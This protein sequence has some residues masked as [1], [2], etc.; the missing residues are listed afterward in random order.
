MQKI[1][2]VIDDINY[3]GGAHFA[4]FK[5]ANF[6]NKMGNQVSIY[7]PNKLQPETKGYIDSEIVILSKKDFKGYNYIVV[8]FE[9][10]IFREEVA[11]IKN[12]IKV[13]WIHIEYEKWKN[14]VNL[15]DNMQ[16][17]IYTNF[18]KLVFVSE[19]NRKSFLNVFP[20]FENKCHVVYNF[21]D[22]S[23]VCKKADEEFDE[24]IMVKRQPEQLNIV[25]SGRLEPQKAY[26]R[27]IDIVKILNEDQYL[28]DWYI[29]GAGFEYEALKERCQKYSIDNIHFLGYRKN[30]YPFVK[31]ADLFAILSEYEGLALVIAESLT[32]GVPVVSTE[33]GGVREILS[34]KYGWIIDNNIYAIIRQLRKLYIE[35]QLISEK[36]SLLDTYIYNNHQIEETIKTLFDGER[37]EKQMSDEYNKKNEKDNLK[38]IN[39]SVIVPVYNMENYLVECLD[40]LVNQT[41]ENI[42]IVIVNDGSTDNSLSI[43]NDYVYLYPDK[44][45]AFSIENSGLGEARNYGISKAKGSY[46]GFVDSD[47]FVRNDMFEIMYRAAT[48]NNADCI[49][50]DYIAIWDTGKTEYVT[51]VPIQNPDRFDILKYSAKYGVVNACT[52]LISRSLFQFVKFPEGFYEDL[53]T[54]PIVLSYSQK[55]YYVKEGLYFYRQ[56]SGSITSIKR[57]DS[58]LFDCYTAWDRIRNLSNP[59]LKKEITFA[60]YWSMNFFCTD[61]LD[62]FIIYSKDYYDKNKQIFEDNSYIQEAVRQKEFMDFNNLPQIPKII[63]YCWFG[64]GDKSELIKSC[65]KSWKKFAPDFEIMEWNESNCN[66]SEN[67]YVKKAYD[68]KKWAFVS[69]YFRLKAIYKYGGVYL[70]T[71]MELMKPLKAY[72]FAEAFLAF[73]TPIFVHAGIIGAKKENTFIKK[74]M[75]T[76]Q[77]ESFENGENN[78][79]LPIPRRITALLEQDTNIVLNGKAQ[80]LN[81]GIQ[82]YSANVMTTNFHD[83]KCVANHHYEGNW[84]H[85]DTRSSYNYGYEVMKHFFTWDL[86]HEDKKGNYNV[87]CMDLT[88]YN[89][90]MLY[91]Q[92]IASTSWKLTKPLRKA[93]D[94]IKKL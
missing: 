64:N 34:E 22:T 5:I 3:K 83:G 81:N 59:I 73:E 2:I 90:K 25:I 84:L 52:K 55:I 15:N 60:V 92:T 32:L 28:I 86:L 79:P 46:L 66:I 51:S 33:S 72:L 35:R 1:L 85:N 54:I 44:V 48:K 62:D 43:I 10:S 12:C 89:Y 24:E 94:M 11:M 45:R 47:D 6:L 70:D 39:V 41:L 67:P 40:S 56:R 23:E 78:M 57:N 7:S 18:D 77:Q 58:R 16:R 75:D 36:R 42:E 17:K 13:Q 88:G 4:T 80:L 82:L 30:P 8:P 27:L 20:E 49:L 65:I 9:N 71:D 38:D 31:H 61:F 21:L 68:E 93:M 63:H 53:A 19:H 76:Y 87:D 14:V 50:S 29:L 74:I 69:D 37:G 26:H 91:E